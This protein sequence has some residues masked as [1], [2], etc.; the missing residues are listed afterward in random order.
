MNIDQILAKFFNSSASSEELQT[1]ENWKQEALGNI[2]ALK[3]MQEIDEAVQDMKNYKEF[4]VEEAWTAFD[5]KLNVYQSSD[6]KTEIPSWTKYVITALVLF[7]IALLVWHILIDK[8]SVNK[9]LYATTSEKM[10]T[11]LQDGSNIVLDVN[12]ELIIEKTREVNLKGRAYF[13]VAKME[14]DNF[15]IELNHGKITVLGT[16]F[17]VD[18][19]EDKLK[20]YVDE[21]KVM[22]E[23]DGR[24]VILNSGDQL[25]MNNGDIN[26]FKSAGSA[27]L[28]WMKTK[29]TF[30]NATLTEVVARLND[31]YNIN[32]VIDSTNKSENCYLNT[33][34]NTENIDEILD[35]LSIT[36][37]LK[38]ETR[39][40]ITN[41]VETNCL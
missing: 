24:K 5:E 14:G 27:M 3:E 21:G 39:E 36:L 20:I 15:K 32:L 11:T 10:Q 25:I 30:R 8:K 9:E 19:Q 31:R 13:E 41:I 23:Y 35:E 2:T 18:A 38:Y 6:S 1:L 28:D 7:L 16:R 33:T 34:F 37:G 26:K 4:D 12:S 40:G 22:Y 29:I 17:V